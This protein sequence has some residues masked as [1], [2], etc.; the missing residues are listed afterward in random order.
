MV[1]QVTRENG[2]TLSADVV[3]AG[4][5]K[6]LKQKVAYKMKLLLE[7]EISNNNARASASQLL[8]RSTGGK[9]SDTPAMDLLSKINSQFSLNPGSSCSLN[10]PRCRELVSHTHHVFG[11][12]FS[13]PL[14]DRILG[15]NVSEP[16]EV[17]GIFNSMLNRT[18][19]LGNIV[20]YK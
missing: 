18:N 17:D 20:L 10:V 19:S 14:L 16:S 15:K 13:S 3:E 11:R 12:K 7:A 6:R 2:T 4:N 9:T 5:T 8:G 1:C